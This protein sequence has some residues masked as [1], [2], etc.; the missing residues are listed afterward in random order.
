MT[1]WNEA[2]KE[3]LGF[4]GPQVFIGHYTIFTAP[5][6]VS[7]FH[8]VRIDAFCLIT[9][10]LHCTGNTQICSHA[11]LGGG[12]RHTITMGDMTFIGYGSQVFCGSEDY[13]GPVNDFWAHTKVHH[14][15]VT[16]SPF[17][18]VASQVIVMPGVTLPEGAVVGAQSLVY[19]T[20]DL[21]PWT[22]HLGS[23]AKPWKKR[24]E[25]AIRA[26]VEEPGFWKEY[27]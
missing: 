26:T 4:C 1:G 19:R 27:L 10:G 15:D 16:F 8:R 20:E 13:R 7:L 9:T 17:S 24:D 23:P 3:T 2:V 25:K 12:S 22:I 11:V 5:H 18:G 14:G 21:E 6:K